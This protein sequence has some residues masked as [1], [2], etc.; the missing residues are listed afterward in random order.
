MKKR[1]SDYL[2][3][4]LLV[5]LLLLFL[6]FIIYYLFSNR[7]SVTQGVEL[8]IVSEPMIENIDGI[9]TELV[10]EPTESEKVNEEPSVEIATHVEKEPETETTSQAEEE[11]VVETVPKV[12]TQAEESVVETV[13]ETEGSSVEEANVG[14]EVEEIVPVEEA[15]EERETE[16][17]VAVRVP[18]APSLSEPVVTQRA[19]RVPDAPFMFEPLVF[20]SSEFEF[21]G[22][23]AP[24]YDEDYFK[25][26]YVQGEDT[27]L[28]YEDGFYYLTLIV[29]DET[30]GT[31][32]V[33]FEEGGRYFKAEYLLDFVSEYITEEAQ[34][35][36]FKDAPEYIDAEYLE[37]RGVECDVDDY[38]FIVKITFSISDMPIKIITVSG[39]NRSGN[40]VYALTGAVELEKAKFSWVT[41]Y[42]LFVNLNS[43]L[44]TNYN[45]LS[46]SFSTANFLGFGPLKLNFYYSL[47]TVNDYVNFNFS[48]YNFFYDL[49]DQN[50]RISF[51]NISTSVLS[52]E[53]MPLGFQFEKNYSYGNG[54][55]KTNQHNHLINVYE[56]SELV[57]TNGEGLEVLRKKLSPGTYRIKDFILSNGVN[58]ITI[59]LIP[60]SGKGLNPDGTDQGVQEWKLNLAYDGQLLAKGDTLYG[61][62]ISIG[63]Q[64]VSVKNGVLSGVPKLRV[65][66]LY[67]YEYYF[68][69]L[70][71]NYWQQVGLTDSLTLAL[72]TAVTTGKNKSDDSKL[73]L[74]SLFAVNLL[75]ANLLGTTSFKMITGLSNTVENQV[76]STY[77]L[78]SHWIRFDNPY[79][80]SLALQLG[81][82]NPSYLKSPDNHRFE[83]TVS[84]GG[85]LWNLRYSLTNSMNFETKYGFKAP[86]WSANGSV[87][88]SPFKNF[89]ISGS[90]SMNKAIGTDKFKIAGN[91]SASFSIGSN[92]SLSASTNVIESYSANMYARLGKQK[93]HYLQ[94]SV[95]NILFKDPTKMNIGL[96]YSYSGSLLGFNFRSQVYNDFKAFSNSIS[97]TTST[98]FADG[99]F[100]MAKN[101]GDN[102]IL[103]TTQGAL[104]GSQVAVAKSSDNNSKALKSRFGTALYDSLSSH[105]RNNIVIYATENNDFAALHTFSY[106]VNPANRDAYVARLHAVNTYSATGLILDK[107]GNPIEL[108]SSPVYRYVENED[109]TKDLVRD[110][111]IYLFTDQ[112]GRYII[113]GLTPGLY[114][115]DV[116][117]DDQN[118][119]SVN[120]EIVDQEDPNKCIFDFETVD[121]RTLLDKVTDL[122]YDEDGALIS[123]EIEDE[124]F[125]SGYTGAIK[126]DLDHV[127]E[128]EEFWNMLFPSFDD[129]PFS[130]EDL[131]ADF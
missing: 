88:I 80:S 15:T 44:N 20:D 64:E 50:I 69:D 23:T 93:Q 90:M 11:P 70:A 39:S 32:E 24:I 28:N 99:A 119:I 74:N 122:E 18:G 118:W 36:I 82:Q 79:V 7:V 97:L 8:Q 41:N 117:V 9:P 128:N 40:Q 124:E 31:I 13:L 22:Y 61:G 120:F 30:M 67:Y 60:I 68:D 109:G 27:E 87:S 71:L 107:D 84:F 116:S 130:F 110:D 113:S 103:I 48:S 2:V 91:I 35:R 17:V 42:N 101:V 38:E 94:A 125:L 89:S 100:T 121:M 5:A 56:E 77:L 62:S 3:T 12:E 37:S 29:N 16:E 73:N 114:F 51:G 52:N 81:Y 104:K 112:D 102:F 49:A 34:E 78:L 45:I 65:S 105:K 21:T 53:H 131:S 14:S 75:N 115:F 46:T 98:A 25:D 6:G 129:E 43:Y 59:K 108:F 55:A 47:T 126:L 10:V 72:Q 4:S 85:S 33:K 111:S 58:E 83:S 123:D 1:F 76:P 54:S 86:E 106:E 92:A 19:V 96:G 66:P 26:F 63:R 57:I 127:Y 95:N